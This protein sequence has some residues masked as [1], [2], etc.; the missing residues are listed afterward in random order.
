M[1]MRLDELLLLAGLLQVEVDGVR[2]VGL[3]GAGVGA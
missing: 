1:F 3:E 2:V